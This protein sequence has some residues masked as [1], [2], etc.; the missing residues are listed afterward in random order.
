MILNQLASP[1]LLVNRTGIKIYAHGNVL[2]INIFNQHLASTYQTMR[3]M[4]VVVTDCDQDDSDRDDGDGD[5]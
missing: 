4:K 1:M 3:E 5:R 2:K